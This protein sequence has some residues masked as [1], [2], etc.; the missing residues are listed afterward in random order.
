MNKM[1]GIDISKDKVDFVLLDVQTHQVLQRGIVENSKKELCKWLK[2]LDSSQVAVAMEHTGHYGALLAWLLSEMGFTYYM[3]VAYDLKHSVGI[4]RGKSDM[5]DAYMIASYAVTNKHRLT[6]FELPTKALRLLKVMMTAR[7]KYVKMS[8]QVQNSLKA[9]LILLDTLDVKQLIRDEKKHIKYL[10]NLIEELEKQMMELIRSNPT[11]C[12]S[13]KKITRVVGVGPITAI[14]CITETNNFTRFTDGRKFSCYCG[15]APFPY[16]SGSS[17][18]G[19]SRTHFL[20]NKN[21]KAIMFKA[22]SSAIQHDAE[23]KTYYVR[24]REEGKHKLTVL[25]AVA[26]KLVMRIFS[27]AKRDE[28]FMRLAA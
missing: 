17:I 6:P 16:Q 23:L 22:A 13:Y 24:K 21:M 12:Q 9:N 14:K 18:K 20:R 15:L 7:D 8:V 25:N 26:S 3:V 27:V 28:P 1:M 11:L 10:Q 2:A 4:K 19:R 5:K